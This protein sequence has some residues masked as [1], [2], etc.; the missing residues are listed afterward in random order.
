MSFFRIKGDAL[1]RFGD[2]HAGMH[3]IVWEGGN[4]PAGVYFCK[5]T[6]QGHEKT[7]KLTLIK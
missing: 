4:V 2:R 6:A 5:I 1:E 7:L 3:S